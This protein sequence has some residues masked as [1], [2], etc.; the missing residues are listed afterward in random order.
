MNIKNKYLK[1]LAIFSL[2]LFILA[3][4]INLNKEKIFK[5]T[6]NSFFLLPDKVKSIVMIVSGKRSFSNLYNDY[7]VRFLPNTQFLNLDFYRIKTDIKIS[8]KTLWDK[9]NPGGSKRFTFY[10]ES[11]EDKLLLIS[12]SGNFYTTNS[13]NLLNKNK[14]NI[15]KKISTNINLEN[16]LDSLIVGNR[17]YISRF[18]EDPGCSY[19]EIYE[20]EISNNLKFELFKKFNECGKLGAG[21]GKMQRYFFEGKEGLL[22]STASLQQDAPDNVPQDDDSIYGKILF[23]DIEEKDYKIFSKGHR[24]ISGLTVKDE[25]IIATEHG[26]RGGDEINLINFN[27][28]YGWPIAS[29]G[30]GYFKKIEYKKSH[31]EN[32]FVEPV[33]AF[34]PSIGISEIIVTPENFDTKWQNTLMV[35]SLNGRTIYLTKFQNKDYKNIVYVEKI[36]IG[37]R[38]RDIK[39]IDEIKSFVLS[40]E[41]TADIGVIKKFN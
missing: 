7:N 8:N 27:S 23:V 6:F 14:K 21:S 37:E 26:P 20:A 25:L 3:I 34:V 18:V 13:S 19:L 39:Y 24:N 38:I 16:I 28:N 33:Y 22:F 35:T 30:E 36:Y 4:V 1:I 10:L 41:R 5:A 2:V 40:L 17:L 29:Y 31:S 12:K 15:Y 11:F 32:G 9:F